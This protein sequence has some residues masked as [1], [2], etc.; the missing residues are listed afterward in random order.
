M[1][2]GGPTKG[3]YFPFH[4]CLSGAFNIRG[5]HQFCPAGPSDVHI[6]WLVNGHSLDTPIKEYR[7]PLGQR[8]VLVSSWLQEGP[9]IKDA[10]YNC[11]AEASTGNDVSEV[12]L[13]LSI[14]GIRWK[15]LT[16][17]LHAQWKWEFS[18]LAVSIGRDG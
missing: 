18:G 13:R 10:R 5:Q 11:V 14:G 16:I 15:I 1:T 4:A 8:E 2:T 3:K 12:D 17:V 9:L 7:R 6:H